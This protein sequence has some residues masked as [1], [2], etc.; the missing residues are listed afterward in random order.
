M[1][2]LVLAVAP[3]SEQRLQLLVQALAQALGLHQL[4]RW[5][6]VLVFLLVLV[7][8]LEVVWVLVQVLRVQDWALLPQ[9]QQQL[10][11]LLREAQLA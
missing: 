5:G 2:A 9:Q 6:Q 11:S 7:L 1:L 10:Q 3:V 8:L 4:R